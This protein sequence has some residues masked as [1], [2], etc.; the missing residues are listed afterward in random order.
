MGDT[1]PLGCKFAN[2]IVF[3]EFFVDN[4]DSSNPKYS[5]EYG[6]Y[7][8]NCGLDNVVMSWGH[9]EYMYQVLP[10]PMLIQT[11]WNLKKEDGAYGNRTHDLSL[12][13]GARCRLRQ[14][15]LSHHHDIFLLNFF[16]SFFFWFQ[17]SVTGLCGE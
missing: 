16:F 12:T 5:T 8:P 7:E 3:S 4:T 10:Q 11:K 1:F 17:L 14:G 6:I 9:D 2:D 13:R 15:A